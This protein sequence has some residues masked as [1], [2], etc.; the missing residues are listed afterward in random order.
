MR[1]AFTFSKTLCV[2][3]LLGYIDAIG[4]ATHV[5][6]ACDRELVKLALDLMSLPV[7]LARNL[8]FKGFIIAFL[9]HQFVKQMSANTTTLL[10]YDDLVLADL[11]FLCG[12]FDIS[13]CSGSRCPNG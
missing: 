8:I 2:F 10:S 3:A 7:I 5:D 6:I 9:V 13:F 4:G 11:C 12:L 1:W